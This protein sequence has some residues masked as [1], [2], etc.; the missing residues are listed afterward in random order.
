[1]GTMSHTPDVPDEPLDWPLVDHYLADDATPDQTGQLDTQ[2]RHDPHARRTLDAV[3]ALLASLRTPSPDVTGTVA[4]TANERAA[5]AW[6]RI[7]AAIGV[8]AV[9][10][11]PTSHPRSITPRAAL[12][13]HRPLSSG[14]DSGAMPAVAPV[15]MMPRAAT[16]GAAAVAVFGVFA[17][18]LGVRYHPSHTSPRTARLYTTPAGQRATVTLADGSRITLGPATT[19][20]VAN[21][22][23]GA[24]TDVIVSGEALFFIAHRSARP[25]IV[26]A[27]HTITRVLGTIFVVRRYTTDSLTQVVVSEGRVAVRGDTVQRVVDEQ[28]LAAGMRALVSDSG[29][30]A[31][32]AHIALDDYTSLASNRL[33]FRS[34]SVATVIAELSRAYGVEIQLADSALATHTLTLTVPVTLWSIDDVLTPIVKTLNA[35]YVRTGHAITIS[36]GAH[37]AR[38]PAHSFMSESHYGR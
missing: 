5:A 38:L 9:S 6:T 25:F 13:T 11:R 14:T 35:H 24:P 12:S 2:L 32:S 10:H 21:D 28:T 22:E 36:A 7:A 18:V 26:H 27:G 19:L 34:A 17:I 1:M 23:P 20:T 29:Q 31:V 16:I 8:D 4:Q 15:R 33:V 30:I 3:H 37:P